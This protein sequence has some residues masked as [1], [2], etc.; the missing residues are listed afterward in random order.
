MNRS[1]AEVFQYRSLTAQRFFPAFFMHKQQG[2]PRIA[3]RM[4]PLPL[5]SNPQTGFV[6]VH[7]LRLS[8]P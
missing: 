6:K 7:H 2:V 4:Q 5:P 8:Q 3:G 1:S